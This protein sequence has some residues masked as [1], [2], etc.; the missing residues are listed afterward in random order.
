VISYYILI[1]NIGLVL[2]FLTV[3]ITYILKDKD[4][5]DLPPKKVAEIAGDCGTL[6]QIFAITLDLLLGI[7]FDTLGRKVPLILG[8][9]TT[10]LSIASAPL[11]H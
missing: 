4:Y 3:Q 8:L 7:I 2:Q 9:F 1:F 5:Y 11:F 6:A 10:G